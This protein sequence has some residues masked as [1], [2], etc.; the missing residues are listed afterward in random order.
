MGSKFAA[1]EKIKTAVVTGGHPFDVPSF[2]ALFRS[3][4]D[5]DF[6]PQSLEDFVAD[7]GKVR[8]FYDVV[9]FYNF[10][11]EPPSAQETW[12]EKSAT[13]ALEELAAS[14]RGILLL[15]HAL[16]AFPQ[17]P[18][19]SQLVG[20]ADRSFGFHVNQ[21]VLVE[22]ADPDHP[23]TRGLGSWT[24]IDETYTMA[25]PDDQSHVLLT[26]YHLNSMSALAWTR[27][28]GEARVLC[29]QSGHGREAYTNPSFRIFLM[30][31]IQWLA[32]RL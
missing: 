11:R 12:G 31:G 7:A 4:A 13:E 5:V 20:I 24:M 3:M 8:Q 32:G 27:R 23:I 22:I 28:V 1:P 19:W 25:E 14:S 26:T 6:Y 16:L 2:H 30:R 18:F 9:V 29:L 15:H 17:W 10:H 21:T